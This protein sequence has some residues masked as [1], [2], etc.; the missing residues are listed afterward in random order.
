MKFETKLW[1]RTEKSFAT[2]IPQALLF[3]VD[4][5]KKYNV[6]WAYDLKQKKWTVD[7]VEFG[8][9]PKEKAIRFLTMLWKRSQRSYATTVPH[10]VLMHMDEE[11]AH[12]LEL[13]FDSKMQK[14]IVSVKEAGR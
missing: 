1:R 3:L 2:T 7:I 14:W 11:K 9:K 13:I 10:A 8:K 4:A 5:S 12:L 6:E